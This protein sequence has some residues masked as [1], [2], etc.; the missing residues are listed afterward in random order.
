MQG[1]SD[2]LDTLFIREQAAKAEAGIVN[3]CHFPD[4]WT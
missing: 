2:L 1:L 4:R 3:P